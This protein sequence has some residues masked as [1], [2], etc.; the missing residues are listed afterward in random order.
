M[1]KFEF[2]NLSVL[3]YA[4]GFT[5]W[6]YRADSSVLAE[7]QLKIAEIIPDLRI[8]STRFMMHDVI[9]VTCLDGVTVVCVKSTANDVVVLEKMS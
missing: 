2:R 4:Q 1:A 5:H 7:H 9:I 3:S 8:Q 6:V